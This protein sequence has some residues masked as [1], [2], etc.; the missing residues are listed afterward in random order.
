MLE[1]L[2][3][4]QRMEYDTPMQRAVKFTNTKHSPSKIQ[5]FGGLHIT[6]DYA[7]DHSTNSVQYHIPSQFNAYTKW[8]QALYTKAL[9]IQIKRI[10]K[11]VQHTDFGWA[12]T[13]QR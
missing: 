13:I 5:H 10:P 2:P 4:M 7:L 3:T 12:Y 11:S 9:L 8:M 6:C 1:L